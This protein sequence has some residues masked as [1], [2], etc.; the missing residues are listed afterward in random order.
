MLPNQ[1]DNQLTAYYES[2]MRKHGH[3]KRVSGY[4]GMGYWWYGYPAYIGA[5]NGY[6]NMSTAYP[7]TPPTDFDSD[8]KLGS[9]AEEAGATSSG[10]N[11]GTSGAVGAPGAVGDGGA[12][13]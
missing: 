6:S 8:S 1:K 3:Q 5:E 4:S 2:E 10:V 7:P 11:Q 13:G 9:A 12:V